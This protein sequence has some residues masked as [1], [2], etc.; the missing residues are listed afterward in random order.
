M[1]PT[2]RSPIVR[3]STCE[4]P[5]PITIPSVKGTNA[6]PASIGE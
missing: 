4:R 1:I 2:E 3:T 6:S 5:A